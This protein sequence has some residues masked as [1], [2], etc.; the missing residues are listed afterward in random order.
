VQGSYFGA[1][2]SAYCMQQLSFLYEGNIVSKGDPNDSLLLSLAETRLL[3]PT[4]A[5][6][7]LQLTELK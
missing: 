6:R 1:A 5:G 4:Q 7:R 2:G 3:A